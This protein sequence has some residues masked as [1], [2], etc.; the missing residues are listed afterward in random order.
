[1]GGLLEDIGQRLVE[2]VTLT[3]RRF[4]AFLFLLF[5]AGLALGW[6]LTS[7]NPHLMPLA[8]L[9]TLG[10]A[11]LAYVSSAFAAVAFILLTIILFVL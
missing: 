10:L 7:T 1:M 4:T 2:A 6:H 8:I 11:V 9:A 3:I 5:A